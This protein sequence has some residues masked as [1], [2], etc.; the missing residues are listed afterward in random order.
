[1]LILCENL[2][3]SVWTIHVDNKKRD[4]VCNNSVW[5]FSVCLDSNS[6]ALWCWHQM[7]NSNILVVNTNKDKHGRMVVW[8]KFRFLFWSSEHTPS[9]NTCVIFI[10]FVRWNL[11]VMLAIRCINKARSKAIHHRATN[12]SRMVL[13]QVNNIKHERNEA[14]WHIIY[15]CLCYNEKPHTDLRMGM[16]PFINNCVA[17]IFRLLSAMRQESA[18][19]NIIR[20]HHFE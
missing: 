13:F 12:I 15:R 3:N 1:M 11:K 19:N 20:T 8:M 18:E 14:T 16:C 5:S 9:F 7:N 10:H 2:S 4:Q 17:E 6:T